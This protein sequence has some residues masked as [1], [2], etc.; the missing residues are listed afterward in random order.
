MRFSVKE[1]KIVE[2][3]GDRT[4]YPI[5]S[6][7][8][9]GTCFHD[10]LAVQLNSTFSNIEISFRSFRFT[11]DDNLTQEQKVS[12]KLHLDPVSSGSSNQPIKPCSCHSECECGVLPGFVY[13]LSLSKCLD[14][15]ECADGNACP[16]NTD[17]INLNGSFECSPKEGSGDSSQFQDVEDLGCRSLTVPLLNSN[18]ADQKWV[19]NHQLIFD[20][21]D[22]FSIGMMSV[23]FQH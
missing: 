4:V 21:L 14:I 22:W 2:K 1:C 9:A 5:H 17:C 13:N 6:F 3:N 20:D 8:P 15:D 7:D 19:K 16:P 18:I 12:C 10:L 23:L 11:T